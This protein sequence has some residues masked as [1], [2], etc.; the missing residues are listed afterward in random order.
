MSLSHLS[1]CRFLTDINTAWQ[2][3]HY[4]ARAIVRALKNEQFKGYATLKIRGK[5]QTLDAAHPEIAV[6]WF[7]DQVFTTT[8]FQANAKYSLCPMPDSSCTVTSKRPSKT[9]RLA[10]A[11]VTRI[12]S[13]S[14]WDGL[15]FSRQMPKSS[16]TN[17]RD[18]QV[19][20][21]AMVCRA[22]LPDA[23]LIVLDDV[24]TSGA[25]A[26]AAAARLRASGATR[27]SS[28]SAVRTMLSSDESVFGFR[29][30]PLP[31]FTP[32]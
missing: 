21:D 9:M 15:R 16:E 10:E 17:M 12:P 13:L 3:A 22:N 30:D 18:T 28:M 6:D 4:D 25:H 29:D 19:L 24:C 20:Y 14:V 1:Y 8:A 26:V 5:W 23:F 2:Q 7:A 31:T 27:I 11:L 32:R